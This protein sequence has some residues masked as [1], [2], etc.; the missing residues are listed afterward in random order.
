MLGMKLD[1]VPGI[2][3][4]RTLARKIQGLGETRCDIVPTEV[5][6]HLCERKGEA[7]LGRITTLTS[8]AVRKLWLPKV[9]AAVRTEVNLA[10]IQNTPTLKEAAI[11]RA[12]RYGAYVYIEKLWLDVKKGVWGHVQP[13]TSAVKATELRAEREVTRAARAAALAPPPKPRT[14][15]RKP[16][17][18]GPPRA[19]TPGPDITSTYGVRHLSR[20]RRWYA[21][22]K[23]QQA[24]GERLDRTETEPP[25][26]VFIGNRRLPA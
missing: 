13:E 20:G 2:S 7:L 15:P 26:E 18:K 6:G 9:Q 16:R 12:W 5:I 10:Q 21:I 14:T 3:K 19:R 1:A 17:R 4:L 22:Q 11:A 24:H 25:I 8:G 23:G